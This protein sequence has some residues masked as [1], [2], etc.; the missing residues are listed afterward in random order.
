MAA[1]SSSQRHNLDHEESTA[2]N[3]P[4]QHQETKTHSRSTLPSASE[5]F[6]WTCVATLPWSRPSQTPHLQTVAVSESQLQNGAWCGQL[7]RLANTGYSRT[8]G[9]FLG[10][11]TLASAWHNRPSKLQLPEDR[12]SL[13]HKQ[14]P[15]APAVQLPRQ[16]PHRR[17]VA[18]RPQPHLARCAPLR[19]LAACRH[20]PRPASNLRQFCPNLQYHTTDHAHLGRGQTSKQ[21]PLAFP[22]SHLTSRHPRRSDLPHQPSH[23]ATAH[24]SHYW[25]C[26][27]ASARLERVAEAGPQAHCLLSNSL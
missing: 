15:T 11:C 27:C 25:I 9:L 6:L 21:L 14:L 13:P 2:T 18:A 7:F 16:Q 19:C 10:S 5:W 22:N 26:T 1:P 23:T 12:P 8:R 3:D 24:R 17:L 20:D 4:T